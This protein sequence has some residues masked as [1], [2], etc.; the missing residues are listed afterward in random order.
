MQLWRP[1]I[2]LFG[3]EISP[4]MLGISWP[5]GKI[6]CHSDSLIVKA[7]P[8]R[9]SIPLRDIDAVEFKKMKISRILLGDRLEIR[10]H[11]GAPVR[12]VFSWYGLSSVVR[13]LEEMGVR[14]VT[15]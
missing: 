3:F 4:W 9:V 6:E 14:V 7:W 12:I 15:K 10:H 2:R 8:L 1:L 5:F 11:A 13:L